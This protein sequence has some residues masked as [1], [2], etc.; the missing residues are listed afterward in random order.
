MVIRLQYRRKAFVD[1]GR[2][3]CPLLMRGNEN[4]EHCLGCPS[5]RKTHLDASEPW[6]ECD[7]LVNVAVQSSF[8]T[9]RIV[10]F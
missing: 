10:N 5:L 1:R 7:P 6:I 3:A 4:I 8:A 2:V 9:Q